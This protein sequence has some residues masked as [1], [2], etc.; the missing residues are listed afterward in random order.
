MVNGLRDALLAPLRRT[1]GG[2]ERW[3]LRRY[4]IEDPAGC[5]GR[6]CPGLPGQR[7]QEAVARPLRIRFAPCALP[8]LRPCRLPHE[9]RYQ[10]LHSLAHELPHLDAQHLSRVHLLVQ[11]LDD[12][13]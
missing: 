6:S 1:L 13:A 4:D 3:I 11:E 2:L 5:G 9:L 10:G 7:L 8:L 12:A